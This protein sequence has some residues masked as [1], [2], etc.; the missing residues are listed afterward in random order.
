MKTVLIAAGGTGGHIFPALALAEQLRSNGVGVHWVGSSREIEQ[1]V[2]EPHFP[3]SRLRVESLRGRGR[4]SLLWAPLKLIRAMWQSLKIV[5][6][7]R[8]DVVVTFGSFV[9]GPI[10]L[11]SW[12]C[13]IP[14][15]VHE[16]NA[17][18]GMTNRLLVKLAKQVLVAFPGAFSDKVGHSVV[19]NPVRQSLLNLPE[20]R[21]RFAERQMP[22]RVLILGG[23]QGA[24]QLNQVVSQWVLTYALPEEVTVWHQVGLNH[25]D[26]MKCAYQ[27]CD[28]NVRVDGFIDDMD[29]AYAW[30]DLV[31]CR[32]GALT[33]SELMAV[34]VASILVPFPYAV[35]DH[36]YLNAQILKQSQAAYV[37]R[38]A[39]FTQ[40]KLQSMVSEYLSH[41]GGGTSQSLCHQQAEAAYQL[42]QRDSTTLIV[43]TLLSV[44]RR[45]RDRAYAE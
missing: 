5:R 42:A 28:I 2:V 37:V 31:V 24:R 34:G 32:S 21:T 38:E 14:L 35:D 4:V 19:G 36:Q 39:E 23:S 7:K 18:P 15:V 41:C 29:A 45:K 40:T 10:G 8:P 9:S 13:R 33:V 22:L 30:A 44:T 25:V 16:Q 1:R 20:P 27:S 17:L 43:E 3:L 11:A 26:D 6:A 12:L